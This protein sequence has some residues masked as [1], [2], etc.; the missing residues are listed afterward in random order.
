MLYLTVI[1]LLAHCVG[2]ALAVYEEDFPS[3][4]IYVCNCVVFFDHIN[5]IKP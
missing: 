3:A 5:L 2:I 4:I 1:L